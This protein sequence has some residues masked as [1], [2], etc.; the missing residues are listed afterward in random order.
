MHGRLNGGMQMGLY[1]KHTTNNFDP[2]NT[3]YR[4]KYIYIHAHKFL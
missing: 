4:N 3:Y 1:K 2:N